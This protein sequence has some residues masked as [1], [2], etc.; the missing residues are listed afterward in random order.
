MGNVLHSPTGKRIDDVVYF[1]FP[2][3]NNAMEY[4]AV[5]SGEKIAGALGP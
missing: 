4:E 5:I 2:T 1:E 3:T